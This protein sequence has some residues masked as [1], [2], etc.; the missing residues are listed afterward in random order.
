MGS[1]RHGFMR[2]FF[3]SAQVFVIAIPVV[4]NVTAAQIVFK[5]VAN[6]IGQAGARQLSNGFVCKLLTHNTSF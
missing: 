4:S 2:S 6:S 5:E 3:K 1:R